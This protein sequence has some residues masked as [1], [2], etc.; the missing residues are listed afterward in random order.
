M[1]IDFHFLDSIPSGIFSAW[2][3]QLGHTFSDT[4]LAM[5][6]V[7][8]RQPWNSS[9]TTRPHKAPA[10]WG[11]RID[12]S[13]R[14]YHLFGRDINLPRSS[15]LTSSDNLWDPVTLRRGFFNFQNELRLFEESRLQPLPPTPRMLAPKRT[16]ACIL[17]STGVLALQAATGDLLWYYI[18]FSTMTVTYYKYLYVYLYVPW[19]CLRLHIMIPEVLAALWGE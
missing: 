6:P 5:W 11:S 16:V 7:S 12:R 17:L 18:V 1:F 10:L 14:L 8:K 2:T 13:I 15:F 4:F 3:V 9:A 19:L